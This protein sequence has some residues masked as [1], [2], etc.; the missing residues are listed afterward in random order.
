MVVLNYWLELAGVRPRLDWTAERLAVQRGWRWAGRRPGRSTTV[1]R[2]ADRWAG[3]VHIVWHAVPAW[4]STAATLSKRV[5]LGLW[6]E[7]GGSRCC[8]S[9][10]AERELP[11]YVR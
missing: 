9:V 7:G 2:L 5:S 6:T 11:C 4:T 8:G 3:C 1:R 10:S